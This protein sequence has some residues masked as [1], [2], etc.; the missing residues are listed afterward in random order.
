MEKNR[1][2]IGYNAFLNVVRQS[3]SIVFPLITYPYAL[4]MLGV[5]GIGK[6]NYCNSIVSYFSLVAMLGVTNYAVREGAKRKESRI[7]FQEFFSQILSINLISTIVSYILLFGALFCLENL[8][9]FTFLILIQS[10]S[11]FLTTLSIEWVNIVYED[12]VLITIRSVFAHIISLVL[13]FVFVHSPDDYYLYAAITVITNGFVCL[14]N[15]LHCRKY[16]RLRLA[17]KFNYKPHLVPILVFFAN[18]LAIS[19][20][21]NLDTTM[22]GW[23]KGVYHVGIYSAA[24]KV[25]SMAKICMA[26]MYIVSLPSLSHYAGNEAWDDYRELVTKIC[27]VMFVLFVPMG[28]GL[29]CL[30]HEIVILLGGAEYTEASPVLKILGI[31]LIF[32]VFGGFVTAGINVSLGREKVTLIATIVSSILNFALN[33]IIIPLFSHNGAAITTLISEALV[34]IFCFAI[35]PNKKKYFQMDELLQSLLHACLGSAL[36]V[37]ITFIAK[38]FSNNN[39]IIIVSVIISSV[40][41]YL[42][43]LFALKDVTLKRLLVSLAISKK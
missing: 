11:I 13:L 34:F 28:V 18:T 16:A 3:L 39:I 23:M 24:V 26:A 17:L 22:L 37:V 38:S 32:A 10:I 33:L 30:S 36:I 20:Y 8:R 1:K 4:R 15:I 25:Y 21:V 42:I 27:N 31:S 7:K 9:S 2:S 5:E 40:L 29:I 12:F 19:I 41:C 6:I 14:T 43:V 35:L